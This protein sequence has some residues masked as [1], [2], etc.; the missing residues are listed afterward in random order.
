MTQI[1]L[2]CGEFSKP[3]YD[4]RLTELLFVNYEE[5]SPRE[6]ARID[7]ATEF[8][9]L[10]VAEYTVT[11][12]GVQVFRTDLGTS[13]ESSRVEIRVPDDVPKEKAVFWLADLVRNIM[14]LGDF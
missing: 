9:E 14:N 3:E 4:A 5:M 1:F 11:A 6:K 7:R 2:P 13:N 8:G 10:Y 12:S